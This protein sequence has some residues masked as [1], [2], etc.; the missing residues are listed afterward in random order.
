MMGDVDAAEREEA[1]RRQHELGE[2]AYRAYKR[3]WWWFAL[4]VALYTAASTAGALL[5]WWALR[6]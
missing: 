1:F 5:V 3:I 6:H 4:R 2:R